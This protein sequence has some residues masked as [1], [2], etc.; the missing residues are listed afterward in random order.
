VKVLEEETGRNPC[1]SDRMGVLRLL[2]NVL[3][4]VHSI[5]RADILGRVNLFLY[6]T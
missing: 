2:L 3:E 1:L 4:S 5:L 6:K